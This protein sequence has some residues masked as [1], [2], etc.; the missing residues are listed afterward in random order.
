MKAGSEC[1]LTLRVRIT[2]I[3][4]I[5][6]LLAVAVSDGMIWMMFRHTLLNEAEQ[7]LLRKNLAVQYDYLK[8]LNH[9]EDEPTDF[10]LQYYFK[11]YADDYVICLR[12]STEIYNQTILKLSDLQ[13]IAWNTS[14]HSK[15]TAIAKL[16]VSDRKLLVVKTTYSGG[17]AAYVVHDL[18]DVMYRL[19]LLALEMLGILLGVCIMA[20]SVLYLLLRRTLKPLGVLSDSTKQIA[21]GAYHERAAVSSQDEIGMLAADFNKMADAVQEKIAS[22]ADS[23][24]RKTM[25]M[26]DFSHELKTP[27]T[28]IS[29]YAQTLRTVKLS[30]EEQAE[31]LGF[32]Y[33]ESKRL[34]R[35]AKKMMRLM[36]L[37]RTESLQ[38]TGIDCAELL[39]AVIAT[40][41]PIANQMDI[42]LKIEA[43]SGQISGDY[44]LLHDALC[45][46]TENAM[47]FSHAGQ[48]VLL[49]AENGCIT[50]KDSGCGI[51]AD[52]IK[53]L[54]E[55]FYMVDKSRSRQSGGV[56]LGL[57]LVKQILQ[58]HGA[59]MVIESQIGVGTTVKLHFVYT[60]LNT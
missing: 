38:M 11:Q 53:N 14:P 7:T 13:R 21:A 42:R 36:Q 3:A 41:K 60:P 6:I 46:L 2:A 39:N 37:D 19:R 10:Q 55:P 27:L 50:V 22:L 47:K 45:N 23:E 16:K 5:A 51:S 49:G 34:D 52:E 26:A 8:F 35:L 25:F 40:C 33:S 15:D 12:D 43:C 4:V 44:D 20:V 30:V 58:L 31:A 56:G 28:A 18:S 9:I 48:T 17:I 24:Q 1:R 32:I 57:S 54:T 29:G 59:E